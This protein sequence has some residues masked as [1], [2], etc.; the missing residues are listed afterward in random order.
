MNCAS[1]EASVE[2]NPVL[3]PAADAPL[4]CEETDFD[5]LPAEVEEGGSLSLFA[6]ADDDESFDES[7]DEEDDQAVLVTDAPFVP[8][9]SLFAEVEPLASD[10]GAEPTEEVEAGAAVV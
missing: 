5:P 3:D 1:T 4:C 8:D 10:A 6:S 9:E 2:A 7:A